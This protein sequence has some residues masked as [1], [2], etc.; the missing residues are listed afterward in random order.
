M[1]FNS[2]Y[3]LKKKQFVN[4]FLNKLYLKKKFEIRFGAIFEYVNIVNAKAKKTFK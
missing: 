1:L 2:L 3:N 4:I